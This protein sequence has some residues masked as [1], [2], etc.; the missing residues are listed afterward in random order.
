MCPSNVG[1]GK[2]NCNA[3]CGGA[4]HLAHVS[5]PD[6]ACAGVHKRAGALSLPLASCFPGPFYTASGELRDPRLSSRS[7][8][9][10]SERLVHRPKGTSSKR[11]I[12]WSADLP[13]CLSPVDKSVPLASF[14][15]SS[16]SSR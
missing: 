3:H 16:V 7:P 2:T 11:D 4:D 12:A 10:G 8:G 5:A 6:P 13:T 1:A 9:T 15:A 14:V